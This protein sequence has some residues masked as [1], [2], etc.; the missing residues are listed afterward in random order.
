MAFRLISL[1]RST[2]GDSMSTSVVDFLIELSQD[3]FRAEQ[4]KTDPSSVI[5]SA[6][7]GR[8][9]IEALISA[10]PSKIDGYL[11]VAKKKTKK[12]PGPKKPNPS[13]E[14]SNRKTLID[15]PEN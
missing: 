5:G 2:S 12:K 3:P 4:F 7:I 8:E 6:T 13:A 15:W 14:P 11:A 9:E 1:H 10:D